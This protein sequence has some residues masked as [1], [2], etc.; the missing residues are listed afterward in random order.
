LWIDVAALLQGVW[1]GD[2]F[3]TGRFHDLLGFGVAK[4]R[5]HVTATPQGGSQSENGRRVTA[6]AFADYRK[7]AFAFG[8]RLHIKTAVNSGCERED[9]LFVPVQNV[10]RSVAVGNPQD[11]AESLGYPAP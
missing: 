5:N 7:N 2:G 3:E 4:R 1:N 11:V 6:A 10:T 9:T 8:S